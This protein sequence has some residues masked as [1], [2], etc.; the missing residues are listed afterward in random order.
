MT[1]RGQSSAGS[2]DSRGCS[3]SSRRLRCRE[4]DAAGPDAA[5]SGVGKMSSRAA[6][7]SIAALL[8]LP[9]SS[10]EAERDTMADERPTP[11]DAMSGT[12]D[13]NDDG[14]EDVLMSLDAGNIEDED[15]S[16]WGK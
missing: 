2:G 10:P 16:K 13:D 14:D 1:S 7:F 8:G 5:S 9:T 11:S 3:A 4:D 6:A 15:K 12:E